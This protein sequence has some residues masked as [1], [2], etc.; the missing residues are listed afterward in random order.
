MLLDHQTQPRKLRTHIAFLVII[1]S[2]QNCNC[3]KHANNHHDSLHLQQKAQRVSSRCV[4][5][6]GQAV[7]D[8]IAIAWLRTGRSSLTST[9]QTVK[10]SCANVG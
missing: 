10:P 8:E 6:R 5:K 4:A 9:D 2:D 3:D 7:L 1:D